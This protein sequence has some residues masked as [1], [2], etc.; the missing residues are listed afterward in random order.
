MSTANSDPPMPPPHVPP[1]DPSLEQYHRLMSRLSLAGLVVCPAIALLPPRKLDVYTFG[2]GMLWIGSAN[3]VARNY[4]GLSLWDRLGRNM[5]SSDTGG[6][7]TER[8]RE[9][10]RRLREERLRG[11]EEQEKK[12][13][14][15]RGLLGRIWMGGE[16]AD[17]KEKR[18]E[19]ERKALE[20][21]KGY[22]DVIMDQIREVW[23]GEAQQVEEEVK[24][25]G[26][27]E[28]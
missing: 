9:V 7:P 24:G 12:G 15:R 28:A 5:E 13:E 3:T 20:E 8:A 4:S 27:K 2:L 1:S 23:K 6:M 21:G 11:R 18:M 22:S 14:E 25:G 10:Q 17:W 16:G 26:E 19:E